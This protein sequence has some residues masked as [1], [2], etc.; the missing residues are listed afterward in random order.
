[1]KKKVEF[2]GTREG[3]ILQLDSECDFE[4]ILSGIHEKM[5]LGRNFF[6]GA[7]V[8]GVE[9]RTLNNREKR[10]VEDLFKSSSL[11]VARLDFI[12]RLGHNS[13][14]EKSKTNVSAIKETPVK[15][16][17]AKAIPAK[18]PETSAVQ[19]AA[20]KT[21]E[22][23]KIVFG[24]L[25]SG[26]NITYAGHVIVVGDV[27]PGAEIVAE[28]HIVIMGTLRG[29]A[30][31]GA[32]GDASATITAFRLNP[33]QLRIG[34]LITRPPEG[35]LTSELPEIARIRDGNIVIEPYL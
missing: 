9:G 15:A 31:A 14:S 4:E 11:E 21:G 3:M 34:S 6:S 17:P 20:E 10:A 28:G 18:V 13:S 2:K 32:A 8:I 35:G 19:K 27:N 24:T 16:S 7:K 23:A 1:M 29:V 33:T 22:E 26:R 30:H 5:T 25:R 12:D